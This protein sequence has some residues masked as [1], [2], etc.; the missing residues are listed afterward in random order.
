MRSE[1]K[2]TYGPG[3]DRGCS[4]RRACDPLGTG[5]PGPAELRCALFVQPVFQVRNR[6]YTQQSHSAHPDRPF[7]CR[8]IRQQLREPGPAWPVLDRRHGGCGVWHRLPPASGHHD[9]SCDHGGSGRR[10]AMGW[11]R[12]RLSP[13]VQHGRVHHD[14]DAQL[15]R[16]LLHSLPDIRPNVGPRHL[17]SHDQDDQPGQLATDVGWAE[18][19]ICRVLHRVCDH[20]GDMGQVQA[21]L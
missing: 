14:P 11:D 1:Q 10:G 3:R 18:R 4:P 12:R 21:G 5:V 9:P 20:V 13:T 2:C 8:G 15:H 19:G 16:R 6:I 17:L 7:R